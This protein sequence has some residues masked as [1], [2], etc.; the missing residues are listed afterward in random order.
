MV[1]RI[2]TQRASLTTELLVAMALLI[3]VLAPVAYSFAAERRYAR[4]AYQ[5]AVA[6]EIVD[7]EMEVLAAGEWRSHLFGAH[8]Y[9]VNAE[10]A[11]NLP[12]GHFRLTIAEKK[13]TL[14]WSPDRRMPGLPVIIRQASLP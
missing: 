3:G 7:G 9:E 12:P 6:M 2:S 14:E 8:D 10:A 13:L 5:H 4:A 11:A 1:I